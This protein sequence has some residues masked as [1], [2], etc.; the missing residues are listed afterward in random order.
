MDG[1]TAVLTALNLSGGTL[2]LNANGNA[3]T[4]AITATNVGT[5]ATTTIK[6]SSIANVSSTAQI[7]LISYTGT[8]PFASLSLA[9]A[10]AGYAAALVDD[11][12]NSSI[13]LSI[14]NL[15]PPTP[16]T[17]RITGVSISGTTLTLTATNGALNGQFMLLGTT[18][19]ALPLSQWTP[20][21]TNNFDAAGNLN[22]SANIINPAA[23]QEF[24]LL[25]QPR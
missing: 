24:Y 1:A 12:A 9:T 7:P 17:P 6:I 18:N 25:S 3:A 4:A 22:L 23:P 16:P 19:L 21:F 10:P 20:V 13:D 8:D 2:Q 5:G 11:T 15:V 14:T